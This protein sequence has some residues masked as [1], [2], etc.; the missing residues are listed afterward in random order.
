MRSANKCLTGKRW[1]AAAV[2]GLTAICFLPQAN[3]DS[4]STAP[5]PYP[6]KGKIAI[7]IDRLGNG[8]DGTQELFELP[9]PLTV[10]ISPASKTSLL[11]AEKASR[12]DKETIVSIPLQHQAYP[13]TR[14]NPDVIHPAMSN[15]AVKSAFKKYIDS[16]L[17]GQIV[18]IMLPS[19]SPLTANVRVVDTIMEEAGKRRLY[20]LDGIRQSHSAVA[21]SADKYGIAVTRPWNVIDEMYSSTYIRQKLRQAIKRASRTGQAVA[22]GHVGVQGKLTAKAIADSIPL[23][24]RYRVKPVFLS[25][26]QTERVRD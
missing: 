2:L 7:V 13:V 4:H 3:A 21:I 12:T 9:I 14:E 23:M 17:P 16:F 6:W 1:I 26:L 8:F 24:I 5:W 15:D 11:D 20:V 10:A 18:G 19:Q 22:L 25:E